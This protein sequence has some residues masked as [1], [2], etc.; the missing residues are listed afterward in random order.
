[1]SG[2]DAIDKRLAEK[3]LKS[4]ERLGIALPDDAQRAK[5]KALKEELSSL[6]I[7][8]AKNNNEDKT[9][10]QFTREQLRGMP[11]SFV[12]ELEKDSD[13]LY[14]VTV[15]Y[16]H[17]FPI[18][19]FCAVPETRAALE[20]ANGT[21]CAENVA[22]IERMIALRAEAAAMLGYKT[23]ADFVLEERMAK[24]QETVAKFLSELSE[25]LTPKLEAE[26]AKLLALKKAE[27]GD[28]SEPKL[29][30]S[31]WRYYMRVLKEKE[32]QL[33]EEQI[34]EY[35]PMAHVTQQMLATYEV[36]FDCKFNEV[37]STVQT[38]HEDVKC[39]AVF[40]TVRFDGDF[41]G[42]LFLDLYPRENK[43][44]HAA[45]W[46]L[47]PTFTTDDGQRS[48]VVTAMVAN[49]TKPLQDGTPSLLKHDEVVTFF[50]ELGHCMHN[51]LSTARYPRF[52][53][54]SVERDFVEAPSQALENWCWQKAYLAKLSS[55]YKTKEPLP[56]KLQKAMLDAKLADAGVH[57]KRQLFFGLYDQRLHTSNG[58]LDTT[59]LYHEMWE[60][61]TDIQN[62][63]KTFPL[64]SFGHMAG[65]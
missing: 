31:D 24:K 46:P 62:N 33:D 60:S 16:P 25:K 59:A 43:Y 61:M 1:M 32:H 50:H 12:N 27:E 57:N 29:T 38:W 4:Y 11:E 56:E 41:L 52:S 51:L 35:F 17:L 8:F 37:T 34:K 53:G 48:P 3:T 18:L 15:K 39:F 6:A 58:K 9:A 63:H 55:H 42:Y 36:I 40:D 23:H 2:L 10:R 21:K 5:F 54:T 22:I 45:A 13:G 30:S 28:N 65:G 14:S 44:G 7:K 64:A 19:K 49:F 47:V 26:K 20:E